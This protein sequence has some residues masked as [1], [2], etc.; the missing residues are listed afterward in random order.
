MTADK[1]APLIA[2]PRP[3]LSV[4]A[5]IMIVTGA[6]VGGGLLTWPSLVAQSAGSVDGMFSAWALGALLAFIGALCYAELAT[7]FPHAGGD[8]HFLTRAYGKDV[9]FFF[10][11]ARVLVITTGSIALLSLVLGDYLAQWLPLGSHGP[12]LY[13]AA[14]VAILTAVNMA[15]L[16]ESARTQ[17][18]LSSLLILGLL[19][20]AAASFA[21]MR[22]LPSLPAAGSAMPPLM[23]GALLFALLALSGWNEAAYLCAEVK[24]G[25]RS[26]VR[27]LLGSLG[28]VVAVY[29]LLVVGLWGAL[30]FD[31]LAHGSA[32]AIDAIKPLLGQTGEALVGALVALAALTSINAMMLVAARTQ[33]ALGHDWPILRFLGRWN[34]Q[35]AVPMAAMAVVGL[36]SLGLVGLASKHR[37]SLQWLVDFTA[38]VFWFFLMLTGIALFVLRMRYPHATRPFKVPLYPVLP[39]V[40]IGS[41][42]FL[43]YRSLLFALSHQAIQASVA[44]VVAG[45]VAWALLRLARGS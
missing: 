3:T 10:A 29:G 27:V 40:F 8:Y 31:G 1:P 42:A 15:G 41:S 44:V 2:T 38:P 30:G 23:G 24:G 14:V 39:L 12:S 7:A 26:I 34:A 4:F 19:L 11:W 17:N 35:R 22:G 9:S 25:G 16:R 13:A 33:Y 43:L 18:I 45:F 32:A 21:A 20:V 28:L 36:L 37:S 6:I 5:A